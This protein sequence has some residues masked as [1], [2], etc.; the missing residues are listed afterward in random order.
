MARFKGTDKL[1]EFIDNQQIQGNAFQLLAE[2]DAFLRRHLPIASSFN[3]NQFK[4]I[5]KPALPIMA[6]REAF[7]NAICHRDYADRSTVISLAI[8]DDRLEI[9]NSGLLPTKITVDDLRGLHDSVLRN[10]L[11]AHV[12]YVRGYIEKWGIGTNRM[13]DAC[14]EEGI[15]EPLFQERS[16]GLAVIFRFKTPISQPSHEINIMNIRQE[17]IIQ[18]LKEVKTAPRQEILK[19]LALQSL[20]T[21]SSKAILRDLQHLQAM[22]LVSLKG[23]S[24]SAVWVLQEHD[25]KA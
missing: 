5:D 23:Q 22:G 25:E 13:I 21:R 2:A 3:P 18:F 19:Y 15:P 14:Q 4:R 12:F 7:I 17:K 1:G 20:P 11:I 24:R 10:K 9:W 6:V 16:G 8:F